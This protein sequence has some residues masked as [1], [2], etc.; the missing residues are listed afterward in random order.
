MG[1]NGQPVSLAAAVEAMWT[2]G[3]AVIPLRE[4]GGFDAAYFRFHAR[5]VV[6]INSVH[7]EEARWLFY[8]LHDAA[9]VS[10]DL[11]RPALVERIF[12]GESTA[13]ED[14]ERRAN[15][16]ATDAIFGGQSEELFQIALETS[17]GDFALLQRAVGYVARTHHVD[18]GS[19]ALNVAYRLQERGENWWGA[20]VNM[21]EEGNPWE[22]VRAVLLER[23]EWSAL[24]KLDVE[25][26][27]RALEVTPAVAATVGEVE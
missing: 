23:I 3:V 15:Q 14:S 12:E 26:L 7:S 17:Q 21:Q 8:L 13:S 9:H 5:D 18:R 10:E 1:G 2:C 24:E 11:E 4:S 19:L 27:S 16:F 25:L 20:A 6:V 22:I